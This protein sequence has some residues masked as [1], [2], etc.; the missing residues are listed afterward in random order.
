MSTKEVLKR[1]NGGDLL[2]P[3]VFNDLFKPWNE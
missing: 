3:L 1:T 2:S